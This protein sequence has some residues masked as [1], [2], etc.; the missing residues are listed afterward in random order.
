MRQNHSQRQP[1]HNRIH[2]KCKELECKKKEG[3]YKTRTMNI[4]RNG[5][6]PYFLVRLRSGREGSAQVSSSFEELGRL[7]LVY[8]D[9]ENRTLSLT[10]TA[11]AQAPDAE[12]PD[13]QADQAIRPPVLFPKVNLWK[14]RADNLRH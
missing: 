11:Y 8:Q 3:E 1:P 9:Q 2:Q 5:V 6:N 10:S 4:S 13:P 12:N 7:I 14:C